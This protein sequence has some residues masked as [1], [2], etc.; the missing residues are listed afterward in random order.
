MLFI[1]FSVQKL[2]LETIVKA[3]ITM[4]CQ[5]LHWKNVH[6]FKQISETPYCCHFS[7]LNGK[8]LS[9]TSVKD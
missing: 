7:F 4:A 2:Y 1:L 5:V 8:L 9:Y 6:G 3:E